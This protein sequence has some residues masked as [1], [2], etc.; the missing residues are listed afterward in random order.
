MLEM[1]TRNVPAA[2]STQAHD[3]QLA[4]GWQ[5]NDHP[6]M[7]RRACQRI[8][9][10]FRIPHTYRD[11]PAA[12]AREVSRTGQGHPIK[13]FPTLCNRPLWRP[14][15]RKRSQQNLK[16]RLAELESRKRIRFGAVL[17]GSEWP[18]AARDGQESTLSPL[19]YRSAQRDGPSEGDTSANAQPRPGSTTSAG[20]VGVRRPLSS[21][22]DENRGG[23]HHQAALQHNKNNHNKPNKKNKNKHKQT[24]T[25]K[26]Q[27]QT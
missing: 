16:T 15:G 11:D 4:A 6:V 10:S 17:L 7:T 13:I 1:N 9:G 21:L 25:K 14:P 24:P 20:C 23:G 3:T 27:E 2:N 26:K 19:I 18:A 22:F 5:V 8:A 12:A